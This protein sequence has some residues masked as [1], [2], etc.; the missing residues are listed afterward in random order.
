MVLILLR[1]GS[2]GKR[3]E[4]PSDYDGPGLATTLHVRRD[5]LTNAWLAA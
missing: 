4:L 2:N 1:R 5:R 3:P